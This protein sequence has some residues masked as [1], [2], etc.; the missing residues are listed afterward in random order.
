MSRKIG[1]VAV[2]TLVLVLTATS[3]VFAA[4]NVKFNGAGNGGNDFLA[5]PKVFSND[6]VAN[7]PNEIYLPNEGNPAQ[8]RIHSNY[9]ATTDACASCHA[10]HTATG[11]ALLQWGSVYDTCMACH[12]GTVTTT[13]DV[14]NGK[15]GTTGVSS[16]GGMFGD[17]S[18]SGSASNHYANGAINI[19][20]APGGPGTAGTPAPSWDKEFGCQSCHSP[21]GQGGN[22][23]LLNPDVNGVAK[24]NHKTN[25]ALADEGGYYISSTNDRWLTGHSYPVVIRDGGATVDSAKYE[26]N[27]VAGYTKVTFV[28]YA[29]TGTLTADFY[30]ALQVKMNIA[31]YLTTNESVVPVSGLNAFCGA[32]HKDYDTSSVRN[33]ASN[34]NGTY[35]DAYRHAVNFTRNSAQKDKLAKLNMKMETRDGKYYATCETCHV[36]HGTNAQYWQDSL[37]VANGGTLPQGFEADKLKEIAGSS[38][39][40]RLPNMAT[41]EACH[42][43]G[44]ASQGYSANTNQNIDNVTPVSNVKVSDSPGGGWV[45]ATSC[46][47]CHSGISEHYNATVHTMISHPGISLKTWDAVKNLS[48]A[49]IDSAV[50]LSGFGAAVKQTMTELT[51]Y[52]KL[53]NAEGQVV[54]DPTV[55]KDVDVSKVTI[56]STGKD[57]SQEVIIKGSAMLA[58]VQPG[59][60]YAVGIG[61]L[62]A[63]TAADKWY[64][65]ANYKAGKAFLDPG[66]EPEDY[67]CG[68]N[69]CHTTGPGREQYVTGNYNPKLGTVNT[70]NDSSAMTDWLTAAA[71]GKKVPFQLGVQCESCHGQGGNHVKAPSVNNI[72]NPSKQPLK[73]Q[74]VGTQ[75]GNGTF[76]KFDRNKSFYD[77]M[78]AGGNAANYV[79]GAGNA[80]SCAFCHN[81]NTHQGQFYTMADA[82]GRFGSLYPTGNTNV[83]FT[84]NEASCITCHDSHQ[85]SL[86]PG[87]LSQPTVTQTC[88][89]CHNDN[90]G[91]VTQG[92][93]TDSNGNTYNLPIIDGMPWGPGNN[94]IGVRHNHAFPA[95]N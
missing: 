51:K 26:I 9:A 21:H 36:A 40:K 78:P 66:V 2:L 76:T 84:N 88:Q 28:N 57:A 39:L 61:N 94:N 23:R 17:S 12:D 43:K 86:D 22:A 50:N 18:G 37:K 75:T 48:D 68:V 13:Y 55:W 69:G 81:G 83:H 10:T 4:Q 35:T 27:N 33:P 80:A 89:Q 41:C 71:A 79:N 58:A 45:G 65:V 72:V 53:F 95:N 25:I 54:V 1:I 74:T 93:V 19:Y 87:Q 6:G 11:E 60:K 14:Q 92:T 70:V 82:N 49:T 56:W 8:Y 59:D 34:L 64:I 20:A 67:T 90:R 16:A 44:A 47:Q 29:P 38:A 52:P 73:I 62:N 15:I 91:T 3:W 31:N 7:Y 77:Y 46:T 24:A 63:A 5:T 85:E 30:P 42:A 32:C